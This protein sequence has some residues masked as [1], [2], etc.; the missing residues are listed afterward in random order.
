MELPANMSN[1]V[2]IFLVALAVSMAIIPVMI[3][4]APYI[5]MIDK[6]DPRKVHV[7][8]IPRAGGVGIVLGALLPMMLWLPMTDAMIGF[9]AGSIILLVFGMWDDIAELGHYVKFVGQFVAAIAVV[10]GSGLYV[11]NFPFMEM[12]PLSPEIG[13]PFTVIALVGMINAI[14]HSDGLDGLAGGE[15]MMSLAGILFLAAH[16]SG[17]E[18][19]VMAVAVMGGVFG[20]LRFNSH[21]A[22]VFMGDGGSQF[23][24]FALGVLVIQLTQ[25]DNMALSPALPLLLLGLP[26]AD[27]LVVFWKRAHA[28]GNWFRATKN[29]VHHRLLEMGFHHYESVTIIYTIQAAMVFAAVSMPYAADGVLTTIYLTVCIALFMFM[30]MAE[31]R[32]WR[33]H[34]AE[35]PGTLALALEGLRKNQALAKVPNYIIALAVSVFLLINA[36][37][38]S[39]VPAD[40]GV[41]AAL[42]A[43]AL[44]VRLVLGY[45]VW[46]LMLRLLIF[47]SIALM[48]YLVSGF[49]PHGVLSSATFEYVFFAILGVALVLA[50]RMTTQDVFRVTPLDYIVVLMVLALALIPEETL[51]ASGLVEMA[52]HAILMFYGAEFALRRMKSR[53]NFFTGSVV[54]SLVSV[55]LR[56]VFA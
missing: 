20:F 27:I 14:N 47:M 9:Y 50:V 15:S 36:W 35:N 31:R 33:A 17:A 53:W 25:H 29:H 10:Y 24:G 40:L 37:A 56:S 42:L 46:F 45:R 5:G 13:K 1:Y 21:P 2:L 41:I 30:R 23:L 11:E 18:T 7:Q 12:E 43:I 19:M 4:V 32:G 28:G 6:P 34:N 54:V 52:L 3:R 22:R 51:A 26:I 49:P 8:P 44:I 38:I 55:A 48:V 39:G 16:A